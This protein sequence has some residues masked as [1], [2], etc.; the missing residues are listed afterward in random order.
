MVRTLQHF[1][2]FSLLLSFFARRAAFLETR[3]ITFC[4][5]TSQQHVACC[6]HISSTNIK[7]WHTFPSR[8]LW[9]DRLFS[10][11]WRSLGVQ[12]VE[13]ARP[14]RH[15]EAAI[16]R[17]CNALTIDTHIHTNS[18]SQSFSSSVACWALDYDQ[19][20]GSYSKLNYRFDRAYLNVPF[21]MEADKDTNANTP[22]ERANWHRDR[23]VAH[24][25]PLSGK[26]ISWPIECE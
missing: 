26:N 15:K 21:K 16:A 4:A 2:L 5:R 7:N 20:P 14:K 22:R 19:E 25:S 12:M 24:G 3:T 13:N 17:K 11:I 1:T 10:E 18:A 8:W 9:H 23:E 6:T